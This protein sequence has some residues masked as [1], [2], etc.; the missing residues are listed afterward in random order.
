[1]FCQSYDFKE[2]FLRSHWHTNSIYTNTP[3]ESEFPI[4]VSC[5]ERLK[6]GATK[7]RVGDTL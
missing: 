3:L 5:Q 4:V 1:M 6:T 2:R 7:E